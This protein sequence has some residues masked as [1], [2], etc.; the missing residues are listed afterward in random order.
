MKGLRLSPDT[1]TTP[2]TYDRET[3]SGEKM[4]VIPSLISEDLDRDRIVGGYAKPNAGRAFGTS[5]PA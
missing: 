5:W 1:I 2:L 3:W 4:V